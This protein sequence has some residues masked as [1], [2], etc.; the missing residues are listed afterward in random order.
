MDG[1]TLV[2]E[3]RSSLNS[4]WLNERL[5][6]VVHRAV[7]NVLGDEMPVRFVPPGFDRCR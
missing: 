2:V 3:A 1:Q 6:V 5:G 7:A 4:D